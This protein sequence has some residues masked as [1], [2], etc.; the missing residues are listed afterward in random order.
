MELTFMVPVAGIAAVLYA[1]W[2]AR[3]VLSR[4]TGTAE[5]QEIGGMI[6]EGAM[7]FL[8]RQYKTIA[9]F[10]LLTS[11]GIG[12]LVAAV[13][14]G[15]KEIVLNPEG[16]VDYGAQVIGP[17]TEGLM[18]GIAFLVGAIC[19]GLAGYV[20]M[21]ISVRSNVRTAAAAQKSLKDAITVA[22]RGGAVSGFLVVAL[23][24][25]GGSS[26]FGI[27]SNVLGN[28]PSIAPFLIVGF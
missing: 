28:P 26:I 21:Y 23:S 15:V 18:T 20:G 25:I 8:S 16:N 13:S 17:T 10:A 1:L 6:F 9:V 12:A 4:D 3:D 24:L 2:L 7:A 5:M 19:S 22:L 11:I 27:Y 14:E